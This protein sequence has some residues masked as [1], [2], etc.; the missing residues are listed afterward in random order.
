MGVV[1]VATLAPPRPDVGFLQGCCAHSE[2]L[3]GRRLGLMPA[4]E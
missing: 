1:V 2:S 3:Y 4:L